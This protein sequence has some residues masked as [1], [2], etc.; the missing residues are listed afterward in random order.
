VKKLMF[1]RC[2][3]LSLWFILSSCF[4]KCEGQNPLPSDPSDETPITTIRI[5]YDYWEDLD[6]FNTN[7]NSTCEEDFNNT[8]MDVAEYGT[9]KKTCGDLPDPRPG[10]PTDPQLIFYNGSGHIDLGDYQHANSDDEDGAF[11]YHLL[12][13]YGCTYNHPEGGGWPDNT[14]L[15][16]AVGA[17]N[18]PPNDPWAFVFTQDI[19]LYIDDPDH[20]DWADVEGFKLALQT[21]THELGHAICGLT[22]ATESTFHTYYPDIW[23]TMNFALPNEELWRYPHYCNEDPNDPEHKSCGYY[24]RNVELK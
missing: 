4:F 24:F 14:V 2:L 17:Y 20:T 6:I 16:V 18:Q 13:I 9:V 19:L 3:K 10:H 7:F 8:Y 1:Q 5:E 22:H 11:P 15:G 12:S 23:C 21:A